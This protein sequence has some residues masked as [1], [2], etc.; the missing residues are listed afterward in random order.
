MPR[1]NESHKDEKVYLAHR[2]ADEVCC[3]KHAVCERDERMKAL[4][5]EIVYFEDEELD[6]YVGRGAGEYSSDEVEAFRDVLLTLRSDEVAAWGRSIQLRGI[7]M[8]SEVR[9]EFIMMVEECS[10]S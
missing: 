10:N 8:P 2:H 1:Q 6:A 4:S 5:E 9:D 3:G 7:E